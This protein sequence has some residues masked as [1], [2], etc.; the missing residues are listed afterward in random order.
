MVA[1]KVPN[2]CQYIST[3]PRAG[4]QPPTIIMEKGWI[5]R[6]LLARLALWLMRAVGAHH[7]ERSLMLL[8]PVDVLKYVFI[9]EDDSKAGII[10]VGI[11][12]NLSAKL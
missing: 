5:K 4:I 6:A 11:N 9:F 7:T 1:L 3:P 10:N 12:P 8:N 2:I